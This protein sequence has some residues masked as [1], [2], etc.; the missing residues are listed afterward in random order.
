MSVNMMAASRRV[1]ATPGKPL[2]EIK[3]PVGGTL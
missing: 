2:G 1:E 3:T